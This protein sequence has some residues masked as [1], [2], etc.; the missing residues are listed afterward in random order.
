MK[1]V[2][3]FGGQFLI[4]LLELWLNWQIYF[5]PGSMGVNTPPFSESNHISPL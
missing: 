5:D 2:L 4:Q 3:Y 1:K